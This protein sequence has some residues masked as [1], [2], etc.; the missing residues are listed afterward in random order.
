MSYMAQSRQ[1]ARYDVSHIPN[2]ND[3]DTSQ[4]ISPFES[5]KN[6]DDVFL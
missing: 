2:I 6:Q 3:T 1:F 4:D 5:M